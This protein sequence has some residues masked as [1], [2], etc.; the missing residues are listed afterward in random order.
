MPLLLLGA[1]SAMTGI[2]LGAFGAHGLKA[3]LSPEAL[4]I[5]Q[6]GVTYQVWHAL[7]LILIAL[8]QSH[9]HSSHLLIWA[10]RLMLGGIVLF[11]GSLYLLALLNQKW[12]GMITPLGGLSF[13]AAWLLIAIFAVKHRATL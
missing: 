4:A 2:G 9:T 7:G 3:V 13:L 8:L 6:T 10:G 1:L 11:S 12:L 5:Y